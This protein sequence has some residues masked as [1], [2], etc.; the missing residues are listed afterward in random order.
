MRLRNTFFV[1]VPLLA[2]A[3]VP[4]TDASACGAC[5]IVQAGQTQV[6]GHRMVLAISKTQTT[7]WDQITYDGAPESFAWVLPIKGQVEV[8]ISSD[9][10]FGNLERLTRVTVTRPR[11]EC[12]PRP[13][14]IP[15][16]DPTDTPGGV[17]VIAQEVVGPY[18]TVQLS[19]TNPDALKTWLTDHSYVV[20]DD[21]APVINAYVT[22]GFNFL[23]L[24]LVPG[25]SIKSMK[26]V[27]VTTPGASPVLPLRMVA[28]GTG[29]TVP[30]TLW[31]LGEG[32]YVPSNFPS[33]TI[34]ED[35]LVW[36]WDKYESNYTSLR[37]DGYAATSNKGWLI[38]A[39]EHVSTWMFTGP[40]INLVIYTPEQSGYGDG[41]SVGPFEALGSDM[42]AMLSGLGNDPWLTRLRAELPREALATDLTLEADSDQSPVQRS[43]VPPKSI[44]E[45]ACTVYPSCPAEPATP[46]VN[47]NPGGGCGCTTFGAADTSAALASA[48]LALGLVIARQRKKAG[49]A[50][51]P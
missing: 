13:S 43:F 42:D 6:S 37:Q 21:I 28:A 50:A 8:G 15:P 22:E 47:L 26:P 12:P 16:K 32:K 33:F 25:Q 40:L 39:G 44:G 3:L 23:A 9:A 27:R 48:L 35:K 1:A 24:K 10:F 5:F 41:M 2:L 19:S 45:V 38:E 46:S 17:N 34:P 30:I 11:S 36:D 51:Q 29:A 7:L 49:R 20:P 18:E 14:C 31:V 4:V